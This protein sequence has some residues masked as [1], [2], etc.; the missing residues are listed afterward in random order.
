MESMKIPC[1]HHK[2]THSPR[3][4]LSVHLPALS[5]F[6]LSTCLFNPFPLLGSTGIISS[7]IPGPWQHLPSLLHTCPRSCMGTDGEPPILNHL[8]PPFLVL[9]LFFLPLHHI[10]SFLHDL[11]PSLRNP[12]VLG[13]PVSPWIEWLWGRKGIIWRPCK[14]SALTTRASTGLE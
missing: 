10:P 11:F 12:K 13:K 9:G 14:S 7:G 3:Q 8:L 2:Y 5:G 1:Q 4:T 6:S